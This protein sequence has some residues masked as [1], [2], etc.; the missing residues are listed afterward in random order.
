MFLSLGLLEKCGEHFVQMGAGEFSGHK[1][2]VCKY[3]GVVYPI[4]YDLIDD[5]LP[6]LPE[7]A[8]SANQLCDGC[9]RINLER[10]V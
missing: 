4:L 2:A 7:E 6:I 8:R 9:P 5:F 1:L 3:Q 10:L